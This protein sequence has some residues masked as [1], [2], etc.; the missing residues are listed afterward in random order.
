VLDYSPDCEL[1][2]IVVPADFK[3]TERA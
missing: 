1:L 3:T 2:E